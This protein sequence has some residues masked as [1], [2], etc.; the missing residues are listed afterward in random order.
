MAPLGFGMPFASGCARGRDDH[1]APDLQAP[2]T[3][4]NGGPTATRGYQAA[5]L[6]PQLGEAVQHLARPLDVAR[7]VVPRAYL[8]HGGDASRLGRW[9]RRWNE[10]AESITRLPAQS[11]PP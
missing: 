3:R 10:H 7:E 2:N 11:S 6:G 4:V 5:R 1:L 9:R 8:F